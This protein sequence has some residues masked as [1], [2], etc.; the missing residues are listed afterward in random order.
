MAVFTFRPGRSISGC[1]PQSVGEELERIR[2][3]HNGI[4]KAEDVLAE[5]KDDGSPLH[6]AFTWDDGEAAMLHRLN[7]AR[8]LIVSIRVFSPTVAK[9]VPC[10]VN[11]R[12]PDRG[13]GYLPTVEALTDE[14]LRVRV[15]ME[16]QVAIEAIE[17]KYAHYRE[18]TDILDRVKKAAG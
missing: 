13:R 14:D 5:A 15:M 9:P 4:L 11:V 2:Q 7:E 10:F 1:N 16:I 18:I 12:T 8:K 3:E 6:G 17:R